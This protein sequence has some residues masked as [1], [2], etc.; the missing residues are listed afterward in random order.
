MKP[1]LTLFFSFFFAFSAFAQTDSLRKLTY[2]AYGELYYG[3]DFSKPDNHEKSGF[4]YNHKR[5]N[6]VNANLLLLKATYN[7]VTT[8][9]NLATMV[10][11]Y[12]QYNLSAEP[13][14]AQF[15]YEA[16]VGVKLSKK[17]NL[18]LD[19]GIMPSHIGFESAIS[20]DCWTLSRSLVAENSPY[21]ESGAK[22]TYTNPRGNLV[23]SGLLLNG[24]QRIRRPDGVNRPSFGMQVNYKPSARLTLNYSNFLGSD[25]PDFTNTFRAFHNFYAIFEGA[26]KWSWIAGLD[27]GTQTSQATDLATWYSPVVIVRYTVNERVRMALR[28]EYYQDKDQVIVATGDSRGFRISGISTNFDYKLSENAAWRLEAKWFGA[29]T[30]VFGPNE[31]Q[32]VSLMTNLTFRI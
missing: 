22:L 21:Y 10:G 29:Q 12:A 2:S 23:L 26:K 15:V 11:N 8:R 4:L 31:K 14:W 1:T 32:N 27:V 13:N 5:H 9:A 7:T 17:S 18:W 3:Y 6:E 28:G 24:W 16:N 19:A 25:A 30:N 20:A